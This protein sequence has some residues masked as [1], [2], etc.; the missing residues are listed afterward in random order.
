MGCYPSSEKIQSK[1]VKDFTKLFP[2][3]IFLD[4]ENEKQR[5]MENIESLFR[6]HFD[7][8]DW[9]SVDFLLEDYIRLDKIRYCSYW[10]DYSNPYR[11]SLLKKTVTSDCDCHYGVIN[12]MIVNHNEFTFP[13]PIKYSNGMEQLISA[14]E[15][16]PLIDRFVTVPHTREIRVS[17]HKGC[18]WKYKVSIRRIRNV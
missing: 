15:I 6:N 1:I 17:T 9:D 10:M 8:P 2:H 13:I 5:R 3:E 18:I 16:Y 7:N 14:D 11:A 12:D 4:I